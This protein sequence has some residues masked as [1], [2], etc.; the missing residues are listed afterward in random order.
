MAEVIHT[1]PGRSGG[2]VQFNVSGRPSIEAV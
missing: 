2:N 1:H